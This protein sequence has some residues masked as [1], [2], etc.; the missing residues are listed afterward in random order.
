M[1]QEIE[2]GKIGK[3][4]GGNAAYWEAVAAL[5]KFLGLGERIAAGLVR[6]ALE[7]RARFGHG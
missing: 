1:R 7:Q 2:I 5:S 4:E 3:K 6:G